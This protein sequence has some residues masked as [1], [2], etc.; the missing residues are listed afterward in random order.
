MHSADDPRSGSSP[1]DPQGSD[2]PTPARR[3]RAHR[4]P[5]SPTRACRLFGA[6]T[7]SDPD[8]EAW[9]HFLRRFE[10]R[11]RCILRHM[12]RRS[13]LDPDAEDLRD[14][15]Q[16]LYLGWLHR[17]RG[18]DGTSQGEFWHY[19]RSSARN[20]AV[21]RRRRR[22]AEKRSAG[23]GDQERAERMG[24]AAGWVEYE[25]HRAPKEATCPETRLLARERRRRR[26]ERLRRAIRSVA[27]GDARAHVA[28]EWVLLEGRSSREVSRILA[29][30]GEEVCR[31]QIDRWVFRLRRRLAADGLRL[32]RR[33]PEPPGTWAPGTSTGDGRPPVTPATPYRRLGP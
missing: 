7:T 23:A 31:D 28:L 21:S 19:V 27:P 17:G 10:R 22:E 30:R 16:D 29:R 1:D 15:A 8:H 4:G 18:F 9:R 14:M 6:C 12:A 13:G 32:P 2:G 25:G 11:I 26:L 3:R 20:V 5:A 24:V 33:T